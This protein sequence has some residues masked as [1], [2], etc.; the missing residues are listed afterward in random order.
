MSAF[1]DPLDAIL[2]KRFE[3]ESTQHDAQNVEQLL[4]NRIAELLET[5]V[6]SFM[7]MLYRL[8]V[9][10]HKIQAAF[11]PTNSE[12]PNLTLARLIID[13]Q[14][15]RMITKQTYKQ[16]PLDDWMDI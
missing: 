3:L 8:D 1:E 4:A 10:E 15:Q 9:Q 11:S 5:D 6:E 16:K 13:R 2:R 7:S 14:H 12:S